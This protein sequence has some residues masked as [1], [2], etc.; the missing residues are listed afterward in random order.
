MYYPDR[1][2][3]EL[4]D[5]DHLQF[6]RDNCRDYFE[7]DDIILVHASYHPDRPMPEQADTP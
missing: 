7:T 6:L 4:I 2:D 5:P 3:H 1:D